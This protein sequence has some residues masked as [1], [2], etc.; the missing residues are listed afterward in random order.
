[1]TGWFSF[2]MMGATAGDLLAMEVT[3][4]WLTNAGLPYDVALDESIGEGVD[5]RRVDPRA[6]SHVLFVCGPFHVR[7][8]LVRALPRLGVAVVVKV[9]PF[10]RRRGLTIID[11]VV[12]ELL[13]RR[14]DR[15]HQI[16]LDV[17]M[18][19]PARK[20]QPF[21]VL[22]QRDGA[23]P[24]TRADIALA[25]ESTP[26]PV[27]G[28]VLV[29]RQREYAGGRHAAANRALA[30]LLAGLEVA[31]VR[32]DT[33]LDRPNPGG[34]RT[35]E[36][37]EALIA[38]MDVVLTTRMHGAVLALKHGVPAL[39]IDPVAGG[40]KVMRQMV[41]LGWPHVFGSDDLDP[42]A[43]RTA[44]ETCLTAAAKDE[45]LAAGRRGRELASA[46]ERE[47]AAALELR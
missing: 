20:W 3:C 39:V 9:M 42:A 13:V 22:L 14:F 25:H 36:E 29:E 12:L 11:H 24:P 21:D 27:V 1:M 15:S 30:E 37:V 8:K 41:L 32:I 47:L 23:R 45:A 19:G 4:R 26:V 35:S 10:V 17:S 46:V 7:R 40:A 44:F 31:T 18:L 2:P 16:G 38:R 33:R 43:L 34:L 6:Y 28:L 5:W